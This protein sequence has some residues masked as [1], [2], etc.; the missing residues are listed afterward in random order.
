M[1][2]CKEAKI[3]TF[4]FKNVLVHFQGKVR[5]F[6]VGGSLHNLALIE[7]LIFCLK[8]GI[9]SSNIFANYIVRK[10]E[11]IFQVGEIRGISFSRRTRL[12]NL[13]QSSTRNC[14]LVIK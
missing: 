7:A 14:D 9:F 5:V 1:K 12:Q 4:T 3:I 13:R 2:K 8:Q 6:I 11:N 10:I